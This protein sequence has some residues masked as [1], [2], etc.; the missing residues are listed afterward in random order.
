MTDSRL[1]FPL[2]VIIDP[3]ETI[4]VQFEIPDELYHRGAFLGA[5]YTL[6]R[7][8]NWDRDEAKT[9]KQVAD[10]WMKIYR[11]LEDELG[12]K[13]CDGD[14]PI[15]LQ[16]NPENPC[17]MQYM[18][19]VGEWVTFYDYSLCGAFNTNIDLIGIVN[20]SE[21]NIANGIT[22][23]ELADFLADENGYD[24]QVAINAQNQAN[25]DKL[26]CYA[27]RIMF[28]VYLETLKNNLESARRNEITLSMV[29]GAFIAL[30]FAPLS[31]LI[32]G[33]ILAS[34]SAGAIF[35]IS[36]INY[37][38]L[39]D[40]TAR[41]KVICHAYETL[42]G[43]NLTRS[44]FAT[45]YD[46]V[47][48][49]TDS[50]EYR[51][52]QALKDLI[53]T[54]QAYIALLNI[55]QNKLSV[56][57]AMVNDCDECISPTIWTHTFDFAINNG[58]FYAIETLANNPDY[59]GTWSSGKWMSTDGLFGGRYRRAIW[60]GRDFAESTI[61]KV[62]IYTNFTKG[63]FDQNINTHLFQSYA[64]ANYAVTI[65]ASIVA[66][67]ATDASDY[68]EWN[69]TAS[70]RRIAFQMASS[71]RFTAQY[72]GVMEVT[73]IIVSGTGVNPFI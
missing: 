14:A 12:E 40:Q 73:K 17:Q 27:L 37:S 66:S 42:Y 18:N 64:G 4:C 2:P 61:T 35:G 72:S 68:L 59:F 51:Q 54:S 50:A 7:W 41:D 49:V 8:F 25:R 21:T 34:F 10:V 23:Q 58:N 48:F 43:D 1:S 22:A 70:M 38:D 5:M 46:V 71:H 60:F 3:I 36:A 6:T 13:P 28:E 30:G 26:L 53:G 47:P 52:S 31:P 20:Y 57:D 65:R 29:A 69:G 11:K 15:M 33:S 24:P 16:Q 44:G 45:V 39:T 63:I 62:Q 67:V 19:D 32:T 9:G 56:V 55:M